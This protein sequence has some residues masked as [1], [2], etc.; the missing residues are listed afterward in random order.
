MEAQSVG[1]RNFAGRPAGTPIEDVLTSPNPPP[2]R[3]RHRA[4]CDSPTHRGNQ[5]RTAAHSRIMSF[6]GM[7]PERAILRE[8]INLCIGRGN[9]VW[10][11][12][13]K[14]V[15]TST[16]KAVVTQLYLN[17]AG[18]YGT[19]R[20]ITNETLAAETGVSR[21]T[22]TRA[23]RLLNEIQLVNSV[24]GYGNASPQTHT[25]MVGPMTFLEFCQLCSEA[26]SAEG[27]SPQAKATKT[28]S[29]AATPMPKPAEISDIRKPQQ[30][31][32]TVLAKTVL[33]PPDTSTAVADHRSYWARVSGR[34]TDQGQFT[35]IR[36]LIKTV[37]PKRTPAHVRRARNN[38]PEPGKPVEQSN[39]PAITTPATTDHATAAGPATSTTSKDVPRPHGDAQDATGTTE[40][41]KTAG[42]PPTIT[43]TAT[44]HCVNRHTWPWRGDDDEKCWL[45][46]ERILQSLLRK[47]C[48]AEFLPEAAGRARVSGRDAAFAG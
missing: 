23:L 2:S 30:K 24:A 14:S 22:V 12:G 38:E 48:S 33:E 43:K 10:R 21:P 32:E 6:T 29:V 31:A 40:S 20:N 41:R 35:P 28:R 27:R 15:K 9:H 44:A 18:A 8:V 46:S 37:K 47:A 16:L 36:T 4:V 13:R 11:I 25:I 3:T 34:G 1:L 17:M 5:L 7:P 19:I 42:P 26:K 45:C 39:T